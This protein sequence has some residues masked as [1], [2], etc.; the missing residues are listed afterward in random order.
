MENDQLFKQISLS[1]FSTEILNFSRNPKSG[2]ASG[3][4][5]SYIFFKPNQSFLCFIKTSFNMFFLV[6]VVAINMT[7]HGYKSYQIAGVCFPSIGPGLQSLR[8]RR[9]GNTNTIKL[10]QMLIQCGSKHST[11]L[12]DNSIDMISLKIRFPWLTWST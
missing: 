1:S 9:L 5:V 12:Y 7:C 10:H 8:G 2:L 3:L 11:H 4:S 6:T